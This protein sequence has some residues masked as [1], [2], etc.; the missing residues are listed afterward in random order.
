MEEIETLS[1]LA[2]KIW[3]FHY[4]SIIGQK[5]VDYMLEQMYSTES[6]KEQIFQKGHIFTAAYSGNVM[7]GFMS[8]SKT[9][10][11]DYFIH[12]IYVD[13][14]LQNKGIG[15]ALMNHIFGDRKNYSIRLTV[16]RQNIQAINFYFRKGFI[17]EKIID[18]DIGGGFIMNDFVMLNKKS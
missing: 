12:K 8:V 13:P 11:S 2:H 5:Q 17:I 14:K 1:K 7:T 4:P 3:N 15:T 6:I 10:E 16:N 18:M 9:G